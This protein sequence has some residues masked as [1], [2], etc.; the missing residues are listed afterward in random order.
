MNL[1][2]P[3]VKELGWVLF[4]Q[5]VKD[6]HV[7]LEPGDGYSMWYSWSLVTGIVGFG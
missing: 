6:E 1:F 3:M 5:G 4:V 7:A 2:P